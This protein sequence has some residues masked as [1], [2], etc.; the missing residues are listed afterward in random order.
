MVISVS[1]EATSAHAAAIII[2]AEVSLYSHLETQLPT[3]DSL[4]RARFDE[5]V[6][7]DF[8]E[9]IAALRSNVYRHG[10]IKGR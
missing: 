8:T 3:G 10:R 7:T 6:Q 4:S 5:R 2:I 9:E 1:T